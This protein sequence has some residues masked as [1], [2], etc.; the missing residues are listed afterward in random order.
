LRLIVEQ[1]LKP[2]GRMGGITFSRVTEGFELPR[3]SYEEV[4]RDPEVAKLAQSATEE[5]L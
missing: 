5:K 1:V 4:T 3:P 2:V